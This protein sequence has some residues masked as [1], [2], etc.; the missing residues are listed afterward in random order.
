MLPTLTA[1]EKRKALEKAQA[2]RK[3]RADLREQLKRA[4]SR[5][6]KSS[7]GTTRW[8]RG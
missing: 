6:R 5:L 3:A 8:W 2:M 1:D 4:K 7:T